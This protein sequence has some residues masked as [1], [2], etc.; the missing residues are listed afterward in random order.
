[1]KYYPTLISQDYTCIR[2]LYINV[3]KKQYYFGD[4]LNRKH[5]N[6]SGDLCEEIIYC[7]HSNISIY[8]YAW[9]SVRFPDIISEMP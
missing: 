7:K 1:M 9:T 3:A 6:P 5:M 4:K 2:E 8:T